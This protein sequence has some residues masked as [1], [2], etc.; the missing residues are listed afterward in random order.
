MRPAFF[1]T[2]FPTSHPVDT[3][4]HCP[5]TEFGHGAMPG[6]KKMLDLDLVLKVVMPSD[7]TF[8][9]RIYVHIQLIVTK[10]GILKG[11]TSHS[12]MITNINCK[13]S[14]NIYLAHY[15]TNLLCSTCKITLKEIGHHRGTCNKERNKAGG[16]R[17]GAGRKKRMQSVESQNLDSFS[18]N[19]ILLALQKHMSNLA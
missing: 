4:M 3:S 13:C 15:S 7:P 11:V 8:H 19:Q 17:K 14:L 12:H 2:L 18:M 5:S 9:F 10:L 6:T 1:V 16:V